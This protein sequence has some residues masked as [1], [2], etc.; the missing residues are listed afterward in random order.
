MDNILDFLVGY[1][2]DLTTYQKGLDDFTCEGFVRGFPPNPRDLVAL[3]EAYPQL[4]ESAEKYLQEVPTFHNYNGDTICLT[5]N[6]IGSLMCSRIGRLK[7]RFQLDMK[8]HD[9]AAWPDVFEF[10]ENDLPNLEWLRIYMDGDLRYFHAY[11]C[12]KYNLNPEETAI[13]VEEHIL[14]RFAAFVVHMHPNLD[15]MY[16][17]VPC[18]LGQRSYVIHKHH[19]RKWER[20]SNKCENGVARFLI[21]EDKIINVAAVRERSWDELSRCD[22][23]DLVIL[24]ESGRTLNDILTSDVITDDHRRYFGQV[25]ELAYRKSTVARHSTLR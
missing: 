8:A 16:R 3:L 6:L 5:K 23:E 13:G 9:R 12:H 20:V 18:G 14:C 4:N 11:L 21:A 10:L 7:F 17:P 19:L 25:D 15:I 24:P 22:I 2:I 1:K